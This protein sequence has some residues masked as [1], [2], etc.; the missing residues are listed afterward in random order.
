MSDTNIL[1]A[2]AATLLLLIVVALVA[3]TY[4]MPR[5]V[6]VREIS[7]DSATGLRLYK[8]QPLSGTA[9]TYYPD[10]SLEKAEQF[11]D[12]RRHGFLRMWFENGT[13]A[14][15]AHYENGKRNGVTTSW[16]NNGNPRS[17]TTFVDD[18]P[19][20]EALSW[21]ASGEKFKRYNYS[22]GRPSGL[23]QGWRKNGKLFANFEYRDGRTYGLKNSKMCMEL[24]NEEL[25]S[26]L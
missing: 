1:R 20:G 10:A 16:W 24:N 6:D 3:T 25:V 7:I 18:K 8:G 13:P 2:L 15:E 14:F 17:R 9:H 26:S 12:G 22:L 11:V 21:Y 5:V 23:Q 4:A 19:D